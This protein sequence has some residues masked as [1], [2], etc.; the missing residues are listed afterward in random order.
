MSRMHGLAALGAAALALHPAPAEAYSFAVRA[1]TVAQLYQLRGFRLIG[2]DVVYGRQRFT[3]SLALTIDDIGG[4]AAQRRKLHVTGGGPRVSFDSYLRLD[5][6]FG[7]WA[8]GQLLMGAQRVDAVDL[9][10]ELDDALLGLDLMYGYV[11]VDGLLGDRLKLVVGRQV[12]FDGIDMWALDGATAIVRPPLPVTLELQAGL[13]VRDSSPVAGSRFE[14]DGT[15]GADCEEYVEGPT[16]GSGHWRLIDRQTIVENRALASDAQICPQRDVRM[17]T[18]GVAVETRDTG[19][20]S[21]RLAYRRTSSSTVGV[22]DTVDRL[23]FPDV[24]LYPDEAGQ[25]PSDGVNAEHVAATVRAHL[26]AGP[27]RIA[28]Y[29][30]TRASLVH[31]L[32]DR[33]G[34][35]AE[36]R[37]GSHVVTPELSYRVPTFDADSIWSIFSV[38]PTTDVRV[39]WSG[40]GADATAW[41]RRYHGADRDANAYGLE[42]GAERDVARRWTGRLGLLADGGYGG[43]RLGAKAAARYRAVDHFTLTATLAGWRLA[44]DREGDGDDRAL[45]AWWEG[46]AQGRATWIFDDKFALHGVLETSASRYTPGELRFLGVV[47]LSFEPEL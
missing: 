23:A 28:P 32:V 47:D 10:P 39:A 31:H 36:L 29:G 5:H 19:P 44:P 30:W 43:A 7:T 40:F 6:D 2:A 35:G 21:A 20:V 42:A 14:L 11:T 45:G 9:V 12:G 3:Q 13:R 34:V 22:I 37:I 26:R 15:T 25:A 17:P 18:I 38:E 16:P 4:F 8:S 1:R 33:A 41:L 24:G 46:I 27:V